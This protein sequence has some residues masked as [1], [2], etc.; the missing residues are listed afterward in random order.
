MG[1]TCGHSIRSAHVSGA[2]KERPGV[3]IIWVVG[4]V[5]GKRG[6]HLRSPGPGTFPPFDLERFW[7]QVA[8]RSSYG[9]PLLVPFRISP[10]SGGPFFKSH[11]SCFHRRDISTAFTFLLHDK[12]SRQQPRRGLDFCTTGFLAPDSEGISKAIKLDANWGQKRVEML[13]LLKR[14]LA[15]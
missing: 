13:L 7:G 15:G 11:A 12:L 5:T 9:R 6:Y 3:S 2:R 8:V 14:R 10:L 4:V 1:K